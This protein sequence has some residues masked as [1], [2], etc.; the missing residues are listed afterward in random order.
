MKK[1]VSIVL[2]MSFIL[3][4]CSR[5]QSAADVVFPGTTWE[6]NMKQVMD[7]LHLQDEEISY[8]F[9]DRSGSMF[10]TEGYEL[11]GTKTKSIDFQFLDYEECK[12][13]NETA[14]LEGRVYEG[15]ELFGKKQ[16]DL[17]DSLLRLADQHRLAEVI[18]TYPA[19]TDMGQV[20]EKMKKMYGDTIS[21]ITLYEV[22]TAMPPKEYTDSE[23]VK[24]WA[25]DP[26]A[27]VIPA[28]ES[29]S[30][31]DGWKQYI[32]D[33]DEQE[34]AEWGRFSSDARMQW[35]LWLDEKDNQK[36]MFMGV[37]AGIYQT[38]QEQISEGA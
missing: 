11:F 2:F 1:F 8:V 3:C 32:K 6:M 18:A 13:S 37:N 7:A 15:Q 30:Y 16:Y 4:S 26:V 36:L 21:E 10:H 24:I 20:L 33:I 23:Q 22:Y 35:I 28:E 29:D 9:S 14:E 19:D 31:R 38:L 34:W 5:K 17:D 12:V 25:A 27:S